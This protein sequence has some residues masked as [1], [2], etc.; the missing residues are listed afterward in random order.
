MVLRCATVDVSVRELR[1][2]TARVIAAVEAGQPVVLT[3]YGRP[4]ADIV[5]RRTRS[6]RRPVADLVADLEEIRRLANDL[7]VEPGG[8]ED[9][10]T[11]LVFGDEIDRNIPS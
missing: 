2:N 5:P 10:D 4:V 3:V 6:E 11:G 9:F 8:A 7:G 1:N